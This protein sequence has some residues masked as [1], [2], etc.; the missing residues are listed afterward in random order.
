[1]ATDLSAKELGLL[2]SLILASKFIPSKTVVIDEV[3]LAQ[4]QVQT[5][6]GAKTSSVQQIA[7]ESIKSLRQELGIAGVFAWNSELAR[8]YE[9]K[10]ARLV[11]INSQPFANTFVSPNTSTHPSI[12]DIVAQLHEQSL[13]ASQ[14]I[15]SIQQT[16]ASLQAG[17]LGNLLH[18]IA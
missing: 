3:E 13:S 12:A 17:D 9:S 1:M 14:S 15:S 2:G 18:Q 10:L 6:S 5:V 8:A 11:G 7:S 4:S 16:L